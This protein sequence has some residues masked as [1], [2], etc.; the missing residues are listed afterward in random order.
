VSDSDW[1]DKTDVSGK[2]VEGIAKLGICVEK[3]TGS[4]V[5]AQKLP[6]DGCPRNQATT[7]K[8]VRSQSSEEGFQGTVP[9]GRKK[10]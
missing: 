10:T 7:R 9:G 2:S 4:D 3:Q 6:S 1:S 5:Y 8:G